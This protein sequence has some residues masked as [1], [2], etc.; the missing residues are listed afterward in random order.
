MSPKVGS[1]MFPAAASLLPV[2][3]LHVETGGASFPRRV[4]AARVE[5]DDAIVIDV[6]LSQGPI[7]RRT[8]ADFET[9]PAP[10]SRWIHQV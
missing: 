8:L 6:D 3:A 2:E 4:P 1:A 10:M 9:R 7:Q 5:P